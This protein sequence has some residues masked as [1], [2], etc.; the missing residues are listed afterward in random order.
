MFFSFQYTIGFGFL[1]LETDEAVDQLCRER[2]VNIGGKK[3]I[4]FSI[5]GCFIRGYC[6]FNFTSA[7]EG[8]G[9]KT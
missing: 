1:T 9:F 4:L 2:Y 3:V 7:L 6:S 8:K 5:L